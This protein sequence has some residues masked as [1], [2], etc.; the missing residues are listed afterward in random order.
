MKRVQAVSKQEQSKY[1][2]PF[3]SHKSMVV[4]D[5]PDG[6]V[7]CEDEFGTYTTDENRLDNGCADPKRYAES[8]ISKLFEG[9]KEKEDRSR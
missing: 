6:T 7:V 9:R 2:S 8:R 5:N 3:G 1:P 4:T